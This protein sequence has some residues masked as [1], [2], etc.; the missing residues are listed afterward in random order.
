VLTEAGSWQVTFVLIEAE[1]PEEDVHRYVFILEEI[2]NPIGKV[3]YH[4]YR[5]EGC[6]L[7]I[8]Y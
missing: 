6:L 7:E 5:I 3:G 4:R 8:K 1:L 2:G